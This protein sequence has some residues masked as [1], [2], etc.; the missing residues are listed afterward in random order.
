MKYYLTFVLICI[1]FLGK[2]QKIS[3]E[4]SICG[5][6]SGFFE[7]WVYNKSR[8]SNGIALRSEFGLDLGVILLLRKKLVL[9]KMRVN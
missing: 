1:F 2:A 6:Q 7:I 4:K 5:V 3:A 8:L 9:R